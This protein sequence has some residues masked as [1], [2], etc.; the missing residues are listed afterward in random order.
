MKGEEYMD[1]KISGSGQIAA[2]IYENIRISGSGRL[3]GLVRCESFHTSGVSH[4]DG[5]ECKK[6]FCVSG[7]S[8]FKKD[9]KAGSLSVSGSFSCGGTATVMEKFTCSGGVKINGSIK[10]ESFYV[11]GSASIGGD[12]EAENVNISDVLNCDG[13]LNAENILINFDINSDMN[14]GAIGG[15]KITIHKRANISKNLTLLVSL[16][17]NKS[18]T[19]YVKNAIE[20]DHITIESVSAQRVSGRIVKIE[21][22]CNINLVQY[23]EQIDISPDAKVEKIEKI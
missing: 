18:G 6:D 21:K 2:G 7:S 23:S 1:M 22:N 14:I 4:G 10:C 13:L 9:V 19:L 20:G 15:S 17:K 3:T 5:L 12:V 16:F 8:R 11:S